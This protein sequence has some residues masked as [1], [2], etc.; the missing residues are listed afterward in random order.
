MLWLRLWEFGSTCIPNITK[1]VWTYGH[2]LGFKML[3]NSGS[4]EVHFT[5]LIFWVVATSHVPACASL[6]LE[7]KFHQNA[8][9]PKHHILSIHLQQASSAYQTRKDSTAKRMWNKVDWFRGVARNSNCS[10]VISIGWKMIRRKHIIMITYDNLHPNQCEIQV[11]HTI[12]PASFCKT[13]CDLHFRGDIPVEPRLWDDCDKSN[14]FC[15]QFPH[16]NSIKSVTYHHIIR[17]TS[18]EISQN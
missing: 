5:P 14:D 6:V 1:L 12:H 10:N 7:E 9:T 16:R 17:D 8:H 4:W 2:V 13:K 3:Q 11:S 15:P 18:H